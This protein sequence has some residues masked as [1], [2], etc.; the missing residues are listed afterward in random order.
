MPPAAVSGGS[1]AL[2]ALY[3]PS[4]TASARTSGPAGQRD[5]RVLVL[6]QRRLHRPVHHAMQ[7]EFEDLLTELDDVDLLLPGAVPGESMSRTTR[8]VVNGARRRA[9]APRHSPPW[10]RPSMRRTPVAAEHDLFFAAIT[11]SYQLSYLDRMPGWR[12]RCR[13][14]VCFLFEV[15]TEGV[16]HNADYLAQLARFDAVYVMTPQA[17]QALQALG[18]PPPQFLPNGI[19]TLSA[20]PLPRPPRRVLDVY[21]YGRRSPDVHAQLLRLVQ[22]EGLTY[23]YDTLVEASVPDHA[24][25]RLLLGDLMKRSRFFL[26]HRINDDPTRRER[27]GGEESLSTRFFEGA[28][29]GAVMLGSR[30]RTADFDACFDWPDAVIDLP[31]EQADVADVLANLTK[32]EERLAGARAAGV[33]ES[34]RRH[35]WVHRWQLMLK[36]VGLAP[37]AAMAARQAR[38][39]ELAAQAQP[40]RFLDSAAR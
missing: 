3:S 16:P 28:A 36:A 40:E 4:M 17:A 21:S 6:S 38:L 33:R 10:N 35:D 14:A 24:A 11:D 13:K 22:D 18:S 9:G 25:H 37:T 1:V 8:Q 29:G 31:W 20:C 27:T 19:D 12:E 2:S 32:Q 30:P 34:L 7:Y 5:S 23:V 26:A 15:W 39:E